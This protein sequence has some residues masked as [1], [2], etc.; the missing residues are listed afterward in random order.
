ML[1]IRRRNQPLTLRAR[2]N[3]VARRGGV[4]AAGRSVCGPKHSCFRRGSACEETDGCGGAEGSRGRAGSRRRRGRA[5]ER[6]WRVTRVLRR[7]DANA[8]R[9]PKIT[10]AAPGRSL[11]LKQNPL[12]GELSLYDVVNTPGV[13]ADLSAAPRGRISLRAAASSRPRV[14]APAGRSVR[15]FVAA[16]RAKK[17][18]RPREVAAAPRASR[19]YSVEAR[20]R[21]CDVDI[22]SRRV[23]ETPR[24]R[25]GDSVETSGN[26]AASKSHVDI[27][28]RRVAATPRLRRSVEASRRDAAA[29]TR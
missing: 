6:S 3:N 1:A 22:P 9:R 28:W 2:N 13:A 14:D 24:P 12:V 26:A 29:V 25:R 11:L 7:F 17:S 8:K 19:R 15:A 27:P 4:A 16:A 18:A 21:G 20:R 23:A 10:P 5:L